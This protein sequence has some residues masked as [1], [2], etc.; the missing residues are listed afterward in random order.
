MELMY[1]WVR[2][3]FM[4]VYL[5]KFYSIFTADLLYGAEK[6]GTNLKEIALIKYEF[7]SV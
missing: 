5:L 4:M 6:H 7:K 3:V 1:N 2:R